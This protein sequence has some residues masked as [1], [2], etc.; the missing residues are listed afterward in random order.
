MTILFQDTWADIRH[1]GGYKPW[2]TGQTYVINGQTCQRYKPESRK[3]AG[4]L[5]Q[6]QMTRRWE[7]LRADHMG[8]LPKS[9]Q[10]NSILLIFVDYYIKWVEI[11]PYEKR[12]ME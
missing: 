4:K 12:L 10:L 3:P 8:P 11:S 7:M 9:S 6:T 2:Y 1:I 5:Q